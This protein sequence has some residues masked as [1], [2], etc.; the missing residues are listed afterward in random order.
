MVGKE[1]SPRKRLL[2]SSENLEKDE[3]QRK[4]L[5]KSSENLVKDEDQRTSPEEYLE[6]FR[7]G[8]IDVKQL[9]AK[10]RQLTAEAEHLKPLF[11][12]GSW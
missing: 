1:M 12:E 4:R 3:D 7:N 2:K 11:F 9:I 8:R 5:S 6:T 10:K